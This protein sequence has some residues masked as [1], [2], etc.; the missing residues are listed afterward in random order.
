MP[1]S[2]LRENACGNIFVSLFVCK[3]RPPKKVT[4]LAKMESGNNSGRR[5]FHS[6]AVHLWHNAPVSLRSISSHK[7]FLN[8]IKD[9][10][11]SENK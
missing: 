2:E 4:S 6:G 3:K 9:K 5:A 7:G 1:L 11:L 10:M 8:G